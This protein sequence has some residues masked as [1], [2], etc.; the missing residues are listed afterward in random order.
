M[1]MRIHEISHMMQQRSPRLQLRPK[2]AKLKKKKKSWSVE[3]LVWK[4]K[5]RTTLE[6]WKQKN[7]TSMG[8]SLYEVRYEISTV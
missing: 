1:I 6:E 2:E 5:D 7:K 3:G 4:N 8:N